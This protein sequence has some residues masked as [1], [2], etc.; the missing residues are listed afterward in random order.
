MLEIDILYKLLVNWQQNFHFII[1]EHDQRIIGR[2]AKTLNY[3]QFTLVNIN[4]F[5]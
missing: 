5:F 3:T 4:N 1:F 2:T